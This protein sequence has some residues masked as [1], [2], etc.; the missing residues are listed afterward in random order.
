MRVCWY[1]T[2]WT[3]RSCCCCNLE[4]CKARFMSAWGCLARRELRRWCNFFAVL[5]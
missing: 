3:I 5:L 4:F 2:T 1:S